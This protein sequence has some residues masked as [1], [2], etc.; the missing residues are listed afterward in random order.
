MK[1]KPK[2]Q[3][4]PTGHEI[5]VPKREDVLDNLKK[6]AKPAEEEESSDSETREE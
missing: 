4:I 3:T 5:P 6:V 1:E 2:T